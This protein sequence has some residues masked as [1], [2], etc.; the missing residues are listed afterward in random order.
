MSFPRYAEYKDSGVEWWADAGAL[1]DF[2]IRL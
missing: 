1:G 2:E